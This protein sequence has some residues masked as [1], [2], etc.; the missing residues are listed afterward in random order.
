VQPREQGLHGVYF[1]AII[2]R[3]TPG[4]MMLWCLC[5]R[6]LLAASAV[7]LPV[8]LLHAALPQDSDVPGRV[9]L[10]GQLLVASQKLHQSIF[11]HAVV[12][13]AQHTRQG[14]LGVV[15]NRPVGR[16][17]L[18][19]LLE[20]LGAND[21]TGGT[22]G[23]G[24][25]GAAAAGAHKGGAGD[26]VP[27]FLGGPVEP[28]V[29]LAIH[30]VDYRLPDTLDIDGRVALS[31]AVDVLRDISL[32]KGPHKSLI[33]FGYAGWAPSQLEDE[34]SRGVWTTIPEDP[35]LVFDDDRGKVWDEA[36]ARHHPAP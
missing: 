31:A 2:A 28:A 26:T 11:E 23:P 35:A 29:A 34:I 22:G 32:G 3:P 5:T 1:G 21:V 16:R 9:F 13:V 36:L 24:G 20:A 27:I 30:S 12:L 6:W 33:I 8:T 15:I 18:T 7:L 10:T 19:A 17:P 25:P 14:A 4:V